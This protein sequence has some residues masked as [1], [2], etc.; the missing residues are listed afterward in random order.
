MNTTPHRTSPTMISGAIMGTGAGAALTAATGEGWWI[1]AFAAF[2]CVV[3]V[4]M[5]NLRCSRIDAEH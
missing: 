3:A 1:G 2:G 5:A 4:A